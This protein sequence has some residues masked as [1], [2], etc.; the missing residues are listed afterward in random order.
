MNLH[1]LHQEIQ[2]LM[3]LKKEIPTADW[4][5]KLDLISDKIHHWK[6][7]TSEDVMLIELSKYELLLDYLRS[8]V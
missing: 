8:K 1:Q 3:N 2:D 4:K 6:D 5:I 7:E